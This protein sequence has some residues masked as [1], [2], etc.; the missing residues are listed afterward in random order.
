MLNVLQ[1][2]G[3]A[4]K[5]VL[6]SFAGSQLGKEAG[7]IGINRAVEKLITHVPLLDQKWK[8]SVAVHAHWTAKVVEGI[9]AVRLGMVGLD[10]IVGAATGFIKLEKQAVLSF[11]NINAARRKLD[12]DMSGWLSKRPEN[13]QTTLPQNIKNL[14][15]PLGLMMGDRMSDEMQEIYGAPSKFKD[16]SPLM[17]RQEEALS[18]AREELSKL[19]STSTKFAG[20]LAKVVQLEE[21]MNAEIAKRE[22]LYKKISP[23]EIAKRE[24]VELEARK[25]KELEVAAAL[26]KAEAQKREKRRKWWAE[27]KKEIRNLDLANQRSANRELKRQEDL[28]KKEK[29]RLLDA[30][31]LRNNALSSA[32]IGGAFPLLFGQG[33]FAAAGGAIGGYA[34]GMMG[35]Q[36][37]FAGSLIGTQAVVMV[38]QLVTSITKL[39]ASL[40]SAQGMFDLMS[41]RAVF[42]SEKIKL[43]V[44]ALLKQGETSK[45]AAILTEEWAKVFGEDSLQDLAELKTESE[46]LNKEWQKLTLSMQLFLTGPLADLISMMNR[47]VKRGEVRNELA[48]KLETLRAIDP[49]RFRAFV[50]EAERGKDLNTR[51]RGATLGSDRIGGK[52]FAGQD[53][54]GLNVSGMRKEDLQSLLFAVDELIKKANQARGTNIGT[55]GS[56]RFKEGITD[57]NQFDPRSPAEIDAEAKLER[58][59][60]LDMFILESRIRKLKIQKEDNDITGEKLYKAER[61]VLFA[62][63]VLKLEQ[64]GNDKKKEALILKQF[65]LDLLDLELNKVNNIEEAWKNVNQ[66]IRNDVQEGIKGLIKGTSTW[67]DMLNNVADK[68]LDIALNQAFYGNMMGKMGKDGQM[69]G[70]F[71]ALAGFGASI[72]GGSPGRAAGGPVTGGNS[73]VVGERGPELFVPRSGGNIIPNNAMGNVTVN[74]DASGSAAQGDGPSSEQLGQLIGAAIQNELIRQKRPGGLL[75]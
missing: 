31:R 2:A 1:G 60:K 37:G 63:L 39:S 53:L 66:T 69:G 24:K 35:G 33:P 9:S 75:G 17:K 48:G 71:G 29:K 38:Q 62:E 68:F 67:A 36:A 65:K 7:V 15:A 47:A 23:T 5:G 61:E 74:V 11:H 10:A 58:I 42:S 43:N 19:H 26:E 16:R 64:A 21:K 51:I 14:F 56:G 44:Q 32:A 50:S 12:K 59:H 72:F 8:Q 6:G 73:Y 70:I 30:R 27:R 22:K 13:R 25:K 54:T 20:Q 41:E 46:K 3:N 57:K 40:G 52:R 18:K 55:V 4:L 49:G 34:G 45:A 28:A